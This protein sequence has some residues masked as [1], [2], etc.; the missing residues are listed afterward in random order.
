[1][2]PAT[3]FV[4]NGPSPAR[5][6]AA[7]KTKETPPTAAVANRA[8]GRGNS[9]A[10]LLWPQPRAASYSERRGQLTGI[11]P[12]AAHRALAE[13]ERQL[14][15]AFFLC[16]QNV[17][18]LHELAGS[19]RLLHM[20]GELMK[21]RCERGHA[22]PFDDA[23]LYPTLA[24]RSALWLWWAD[25]SA[26]LLVWRSPVRPRSRR[27]RARPLP[28]VR[29]D[30]QLRRGLPRCRFRRHGA[31][32]RGAYGVRRTRLPS[33]ARKGD[34]AA[35]VAMN[36]IA[37]DL[38]VIAEL[39]LAARDL[40]EFEAGWLAHLQPCIGFDAACSVWSDNSGR[41]RDVTSVSYDERELRR[42]FPGYMCELSPQELARFSGVAPAVD[43]DVLDS[44][45]RERLAVYRELL[46]PNGITSFVTNVRRAP[47]GVFGFHLG[48]AGGTRF[49][50]RE[51]H[52]LQLLAPCVEL[53]Q[54]LFAKQHTSSIGLEAEWWADDWSLSAR[55]RDVARL[56]MRGFT[57]PEI[58]TLLRISAHTVRNHLVN[59][60]RK[61]DVSK[62][63]E[64]VFTMVATP[65]QAARERSR[66]GRSAWYSF[67]AQ[68][69]PS[70]R[71]QRQ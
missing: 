39:A 42:R 68:S 18:R 43:L 15:D 20:H 10:R 40:R 11:Q 31:P 59:V 29:N 16:T 33:Q 63:S 34:A 55:E 27:D 9:S 25:P 26:H 60:F 38:G 14:G 66:R 30:R 36:P 54:G 70:E 67:S 35:A 8:H 13:L 3:S 22:P 32:R 1:V 45:R 44:T 21:S 23:A 65:E 53:G 46:S 69:S 41:V 17:D 49:G 6:R 58:A 4:E 12:N 52:R 47:W 61:A 2:R 56:V 28:S 24:D 62:R 7:S 48:R 19:R 50:E 71:R 57:N 51:T 64:L 37:S 5:C